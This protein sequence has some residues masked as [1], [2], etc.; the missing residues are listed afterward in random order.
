MPVWTLGLAFREILHLQLIDSALA[1][2]SNQ[3]ASSS[4]VSKTFRHILD[5]NSKT[6]G[7]AGAFYSKN[8]NKNVSAFDWHACPM[9]AQWKTYRKSCPKRD[10]STRKPNRCQGPVQPMLP[11][12]FGGARALGDFWWQNPVWVSSVQF[13]VPK[14]DFWLSKWVNC[15][16]LVNSKWCIAC[17]LANH[18]GMKWPD[19]EELEWL[20]NG[21]IGVFS[22]KHD[23][24]R[25]NNLMSLKITHR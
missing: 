24:L 17:D 5:C 8:G 4:S 12:D 13:Y 19:N 9:N 20:G 22:L 15:F 6:V 10:Y 11:C 16:R 21:T 1:P 7:W 25:L 2:P 14:T 18:I 23:N 3:S